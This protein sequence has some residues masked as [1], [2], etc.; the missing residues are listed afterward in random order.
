MKNIIE[1]YAKMSKGIFPIFEIECEKDGELDYFI[2][3]IETNKDG[4][5]FNIPDTDLKTYFSGNIKKLSNSSFM[6]PFDDYFDDL[7][8]YLQEIYQEIT[9]GYLFPNDFYIV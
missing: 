9:E 3:N 8:Y 4:I 6:M 1:Q 5:V 2:F 7:D